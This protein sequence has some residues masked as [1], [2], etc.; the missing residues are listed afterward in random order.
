MQA[1]KND[2]LT[3]ASQFKTFEMLDVEVPRALIDYMEGAHMHTEAQH[4][5]KAYED[6]TRPRVDTVPDTVQDVLSGMKPRFGVR[7]GIPFIDP[8]MDED[9]LKGYVRHLVPM[10]YD[11]EEER[12]EKAPSCVFSKRDKPKTSRKFLVRAKEWNKRL[13][14]YDVSKL[15]LTDATSEELQAELCAEM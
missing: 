3:P 6:Y 2:A 9:A 4:G 1:I 7:T 8:K 14:H 11:V 12:W 13:S 10:S 5:I 15:R